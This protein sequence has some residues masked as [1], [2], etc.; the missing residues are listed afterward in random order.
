LEQ[1]LCVMTISAFE[2]AAIR[3]HSS[4]SGTNHT[5]EV[6]SG[7]TCGCEAS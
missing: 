1:H 5:C 4:Q 7:Q 3:I 2:T 6:S